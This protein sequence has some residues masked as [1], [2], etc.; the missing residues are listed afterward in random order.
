MALLAGC[1]ESAGDV[2][3]T[4]RASEI[5]LMAAD[6]RAGGSLELASYMAR[7]AIEAGMASDQ[8]E[9]CELKVI[10]PCSLP[11][12]KR[13]M[14][15]LAGGGE[16]ER[17]VVRGRRLHIRR[18]VTADAIGRESFKSSC[19]ALLVARFTIQSRVRPEQGEAILVIADL[20]DRSL[21]TIHGVAAVTLRALHT[22]AMDVG[23]AVTA[24]TPDVAEHRFHVTL[25]TCH[26]L[27]H[28][29]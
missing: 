1:R 16:A 22:S 18:R 26:A 25:R 12:I 28:S 4:L 19:C 17:P 3:R 15:L 2:I 27:M 14:T 9:S 13:R 7:I 8:G 5:L 21:P 11:R 10:E 6:A 23:M 24:L 29:A 20:V